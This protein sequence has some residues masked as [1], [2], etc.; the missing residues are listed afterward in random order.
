MSESNQV[1]EETAVQRIQR[2]AAESKA[3]KE[4][5][6]A[7]SVTAKEATEQELA[8]V[9]EQVVERSYHVFYNTITSCKMLTDS[10]RVISF[11][12]GKYITD[13]QEEIDYL[14]R[15]LAHPDNIYLSVVKGQEVMTA[16][17]LDPMAMLRKKHFAEFEAM[18]KEA[19]RKIAAGEPL[20]QSESESQVLTPG[21]SVDIAPLADGQ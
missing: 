1:Q 6:P 20:S 4:A 5:A 16:T 15:E 19:A 8:P 2:L 13:Q 21:S 14:Q 9:Q 3:G 7:N 11:V 18:Q 17:E 10:G 12:D